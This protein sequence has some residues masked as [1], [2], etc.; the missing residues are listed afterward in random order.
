MVREHTSSVSTADD[1][2]TA[3]EIAAFAAADPEN[4]SSFAETEAGETGVLSLASAHMRRIYGRFRELLLVDR[5][6][7]TSRWVAR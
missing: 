4:V 2:D 1:D 6:H 7:K 3:R 5:S